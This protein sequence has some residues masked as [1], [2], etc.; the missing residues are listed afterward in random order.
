[1]PLLKQHWENLLVGKL[2]EIEVEPSMFAS[3]D[4]DGAEVGM[5][6]FHVER[7]EGNEA[8]RG[9]TKLALG[10]VQELVKS[11]PWRVVGY[12]GECC[13]TERLCN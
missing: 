13:A 7:F 9:L 4:A 12:S 11:K 6:V 10:L 3:A 2:K 5:H 8:I 1:M